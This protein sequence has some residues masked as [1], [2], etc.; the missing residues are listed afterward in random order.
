MVSSTST[1][2]DS[3]ILYQQTSRH[4][5]SPATENDFFRY[6]TK[7]WL[8]NESYELS[9]RYVKVDIQGLFDAAVRVVGN[10]ATRCI[11]ATEFREGDT[12]NGQRSRSGGKDPQLQCRLHD[13]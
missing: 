8:F 4:S 12:G 10:G 11:R 7:R 6:T 1:V 5:A 9:R 13:C 2:A 3:D